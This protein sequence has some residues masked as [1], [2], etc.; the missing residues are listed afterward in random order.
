M[1]FIAFDPT[2]AEAAPTVSLGAPN[3]SVGETL[4]SLQATM[5][6]ELG[7]RDDYDA[8]RAAGWINKAY[9][10]L[11]GM[12]DVNE[13]MAS[14]SGSLVVGQPLYL[15]PSVAQVIGVSIID[16]TTYREGGIP[17]EMTDR[18]SYRAYRDLDGE[19]LL[20]FR[21]NQLLVFY[22]T[23]LN[24]RTYSADVK[25]RPQPL[26][27]P[28]D[29]PILPPEMHD[30]LSLFAISR[31]MRALRDYKGAQLAY[32]DGLSSLRSLIN[33]EAEESASM[34]S[35]FVPVRRR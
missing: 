5:S 6:L 28:T 31:A 27:D 20:Y 15:L 12:V 26:V 30:A 22:P 14:F 18:D 34:D 23:P 1:P 2:A 16:A 33:N 17:L 9:Q 7:D 19:P 8:T 25:V 11:A 3:T 10:Q 35:H 24:I 32:N 21:Y 13:L 29:S 4:A